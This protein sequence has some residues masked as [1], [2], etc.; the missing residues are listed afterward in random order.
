MLAYSAPA[1]PPPPTPN[2]PTSKASRVNTLKMQLYHLTDIYNISITH[3]T[4]PRY[5]KY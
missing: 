1:A 2:N 3:K 5:D 4:F